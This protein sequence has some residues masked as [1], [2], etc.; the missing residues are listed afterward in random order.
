MFKNNYSNMNRSM[1]G[2]S[3]KRALSSYDNS[4]N[5]SRQLNNNIPIRSNRQNKSFINTKYNNNKSKPKKINGT[6][7]DYQRLTKKYYSIIIGLQEELTKQ[8]IR[9]YNLLEENV[10]LKKKIN[11]IIQNQ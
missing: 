5:M 7:E 4:N 10:N 6:L 9:N 2:T 1:V 11:E 3:H 8:T